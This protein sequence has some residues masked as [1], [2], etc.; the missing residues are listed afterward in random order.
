MSRR[1]MGRID[2]PYWSDDN[3]RSRPARRISNKKLRKSERVAWLADWS[4]NL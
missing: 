4:V 1:M 3:V 2:L